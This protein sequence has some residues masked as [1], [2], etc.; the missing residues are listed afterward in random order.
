MA[1][2]DEI[3]V[4]RS[5]KGDR[6]SFELLI[7]KYQ[8]RIFGLIFRLTN[9]TDMVE[10]LAQETFLKA[11]AAIKQFAQKSSFYTWLRKIAVNTC[12]NYLSSNTPVLLEEDI[13]AN[14]LSLNPGFIEG[15]IDNPEGALLVK[16]LNQGIS[17]AVDSLSQKHRTA[18]L[19]RELEDMSYEDIAEAV[20]CPVGT[21][22]S[23]LHRARQELQEKLSTYI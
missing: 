3:L 16:E 22:R 6:Q 21:V 12:L 15:K 1:E 11:F 19:L 18:F 4:R 17:D 8:R 13:L 7:I 9:N 5:Q 2:S 20:D 10:D 23:R 14:K